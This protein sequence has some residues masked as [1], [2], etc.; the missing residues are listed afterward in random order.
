[1]SDLHD[2]PLRILIV[3]DSRDHADSERILLEALGFQCTTAYT[4]PTAI[5][6][7]ESL[8]PDVILLDIGMPHNGLQVA[9]FAKSLPGKHP[10]VIIVSGHQEDTARASAAEAGADMYFLKPVDMNQLHK[11]LEM[12]HVRRKASNDPC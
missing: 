5:Q 6:R 4:V 9:R 11:I 1:M 2:E 7:V 8:R 10:F 12:I 3:D